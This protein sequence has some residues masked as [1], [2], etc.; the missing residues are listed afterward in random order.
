MSDEAKKITR[1]GSSTKYD[2][3]ALYAEWVSSGLS[4]N[5]FRILKGFDG[6]FFY[7]A[8]DREGWWEKAERVAEKI[9]AAAEARVV[10]ATVARWDEQE[11]L[12]REVERQA[13]AIMR[14]TI[15]PDGKIASPL[16]PSELATLTA[17]LE[18]ALKSRRL[19]AGESTDNMAVGGSLHSDLVKMVL[20]HRKSAK[21][22]EG[23]RAA[24]KDV[25][26]RNT[27][28][29]DEQGGE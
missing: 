24:A 22:L 20:N 1:R 14:A 18:R 2:W 3:D 5:K 28:P 16:E 9:T 17:A 23:R 6:G 7:N 29:P 21:M 19:I 10:D 27:P 4:M 13:A 15:G 8:I 26:P 12:W 25:T 11:A